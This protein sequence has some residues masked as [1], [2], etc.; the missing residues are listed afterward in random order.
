MPKWLF[1]PNS[2]HGTL[3]ISL[4]HPFSDKKP[5]A[6][7]LLQFSKLYNYQY[8]LRF[9]ESSYISLYLCSY[10][11]YSKMFSANFTTGLMQ[12]PSSRPSVH[13]QYLTYRKI[14]LAISNNLT[15]FKISRQGGPKV[16]FLKSVNFW[17]T[18][19]PSYLTI[20]P[21]RRWLLV[22][23]SIEKKSH[24][25][26]NTQFPQQRQQPFLPTFSISSS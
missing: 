2:Q 22:R 5:F 18:Q 11:P 20:V 25:R 8:F 10:K 9:C 6:L 17:T 21:K 4:L 13:S 26:C 14:L 7:F 3:L 16:A 23:F 19:Y 24:D 1:S 15:L 12:K